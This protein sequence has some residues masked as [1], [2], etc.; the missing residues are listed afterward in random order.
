MKINYKYDY[1]H[2]ISGNSI[3]GRAGTIFI[4]GLIKRHNLQLNTFEFYKSAEC[5]INL[6]ITILKKPSMNNFKIEGLKGHKIYGESEKY[7]VIKKVKKT[8]SHTQQQ[9]TLKGLAFCKINIP[10][11]SKR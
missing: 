6:P 9:T 7:S 3:T 1:G 4:K 11:H 5:I 8:G 2:S 10:I